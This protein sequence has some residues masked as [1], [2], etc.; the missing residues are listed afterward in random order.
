MT[1][2]EREKKIIGVMVDI[3][4][5]KKNINTKTVYVKNVKNY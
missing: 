2:I 5:K 3:Y 1:R 4:C